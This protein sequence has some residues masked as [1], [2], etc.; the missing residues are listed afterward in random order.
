[1]P[2]APTPLSR[3][4]SDAVDAAREWHSG[5]VR[6]GTNVPYIAHPLLVASLVL[7][8]G[9]DE[10][11]AIAA[12]LHDAVEDTD[13][14]L[15][16]IRGRF[17]DRVAAMV[18][19]CSDTDGRAGEA[20]PPWRQRKE[21]HL[22]EVSAAV[23]AGVDPGAIRVLLADKLVNVRS[24]LDDHRRM[25][26][27]SWDRFNASPEDQLWYYG[28][29]LDPVA[30]REPGSLEARVRGVLAELRDEVGEPG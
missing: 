18:A 30:G 13:A 12:L 3:R 22:H 25:G 26:A 17:G 11:E 15:D 10:D 5:Q 4:F 7:E 14:T 20:K 23:A 27:R 24:M 16:E 6:K 8:D 9:G 2:D 21:A 29:M 19:F 1:M 28:A